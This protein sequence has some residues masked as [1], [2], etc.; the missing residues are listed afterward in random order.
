MSMNERNV[1]NL[2]SSVDVQ[3]KGEKV[4]K[5]MSEVRSLKFAAA[6]AAGV[7]FAATSLHAAPQPVA[8]ELQELEIKDHQRG[9]VKFERPMARS[10]RLSCSSRKR[11]CR[12]FWRMSLR[13]A[14]FRLGQ[15]DIGV[16]CCAVIAN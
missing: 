3:E 10:P 12:C 14:V 1:F 9:S 6:F 2:Y 7:F 11:Q 16:C 4:R 13:C 8:G 5:N 15:G